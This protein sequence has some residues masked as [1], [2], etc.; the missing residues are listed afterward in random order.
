MECSVLK[1][2]M[3]VRGK[4]QFSLARYLNLDPSAVS[5]IVNGWKKPTPEQKRQIAV[6]LEMP[7]EEIFE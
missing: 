1:L 7:V 4:K 5:K 3:I 2:A 6:F